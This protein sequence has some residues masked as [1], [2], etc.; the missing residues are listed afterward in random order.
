[1]RTSTHLLRLSPKEKAVLEQKARMAAARGEAPI[2]LA[3]ALRE[4]ARL[5]LDDLLEK[6]PSLEDTV[7]GTDGS[8]SAS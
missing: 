1:M 4:G 3:H 2:T 6:L 7:G 8:A 5:Y